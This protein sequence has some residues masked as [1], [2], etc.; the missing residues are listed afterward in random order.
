MM[1]L[2]AHIAESRG[3]LSPFTSTDVVSGIN[4]FQILVVVLND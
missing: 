2:V 1:L 4:Q 3:V